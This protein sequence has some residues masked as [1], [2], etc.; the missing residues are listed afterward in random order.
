MNTD[1]TEELLAQILIW[2]KASA[3]P[4]VELMLKRALSDDRMRRAY[5]ATNG[6]N[7]VAQ[8][9]AVARVGA[10]LLGRWCDRWIAMGLMV[11]LG[12]GKR[13]RLFDLADFALMPADAQD[14]KNGDNE[15]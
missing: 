4:S 5:Q 3:Y 9:K 2:T 10:D 15:T 14:E 8:I 11:D 12:G 13:Q 7:T 6:V 1:K